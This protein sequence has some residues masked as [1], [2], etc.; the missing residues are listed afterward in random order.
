MRKL[1][2]NKNAPSSLIH[3]RRQLSNFL[4]NQSNQRMTRSINKDNNDFENYQQSIIN[5][6]KL[7]ISKVRKVIPVITYGFIGD[8]DVPLYQRSS[9][10]CLS[11]PKYYPHVCLWAGGMALICGGIKDLNIHSL[12]SH[13]SWF[14]SYTSGRPV[15]DDFIKSSCSSLIDI[16]SKRFEKKNLLVF[17]FKTRIVSLRHSLR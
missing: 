5:N 3:Y 15:G 17:G 4:T 6:D 13:L 7:M 9:W 2:C 8:K 16:S 1:Y 14:M 12:I 11:C 10:N